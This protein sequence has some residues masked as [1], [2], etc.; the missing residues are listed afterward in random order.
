MMTPEREAKLDRMIAIYG[1]EHPIVLRYA[2]CCEEWDVNDWNEW[3]LELWVR[4]NEADP[5]YAEE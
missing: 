5:S 2:K 1:M 3:F 4:G